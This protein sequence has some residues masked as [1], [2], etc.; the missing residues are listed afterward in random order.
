MAGRK[1]PSREAAWTIPKLKAELSR[2]GIGINS[3]DKKS[4]LLRYLREDDRATDAGRRAQAQT[5]PRS[6]GA[7]STGDFAQLQQ[8]VRELRATI[9]AL[10]STLSGPKTPV[11]HSHDIRNAPPAANTA[12]SNQEMT[13]P[14]ASTEHLQLPS[15]NTAPPTTSLST[16]GHAGKDPAYRDVTAFGASN[17]AA[18]SGFPGGVPMPGSSGI[19]SFAPN[20]A[21]LGHSYGAVDKNQAQHGQGPAPFPFPGASLGQPM[22]GTSY[23]NIPG[24]SSQPG[25]ADAQGRAPTSFRQDGGPWQ[26]GGSS[27]AFI[28]NSSPGGRSSLQQA[29][30]TQGVAS[31][32]LP[33]VE[34]ISSQLKQDIIH[35]KDV[36]LASLLI[37]GYTSEWERS[38]RFVVTVD[39]AIPLKPLKDHR[40][41]RSLTIQEF[42]KAFIS[43]RNVMCDAFPNRRWELDMYLQTIVGFSDDYGGIMFYEYHKDFSARAATM[44]HDYGIKVDWSKRDYDLFS[45]HFA[46]CRANAC[47]LCACVT[48]KAAFCPLSADGNSNNNKRFRNNNYSSTSD[49]AGRPKNFAD[50]KEI[51]NNFNGKGCNRGSQCYYV[52]ACNICKTVGHHQ[53]Q[54][55]KVQAPKTANVVAP[56]AANVTSNAVSAKKSN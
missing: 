42:V 19:P 33:H 23:N 12:V 9:G 40:L 24:P 4:V 48:H 52:H 7:C 51:C 27:D 11:E 45:K 5:A 41:A 38:Q 28:N 31:G 18:R 49:S 8:E 2:R 17:D 54:C 22:P 46:G 16:S 55:K 44:L 1:R 47:S 3:W 30:Q 56:K 10:Q 43:Y 15:V 53:G 29:L 37:R 20:V 39:E 32:D 36:N 34:L 6:E 21:T 50:G 35:G 25:S 14:E 26:S 13:A